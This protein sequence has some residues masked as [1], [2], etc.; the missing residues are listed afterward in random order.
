MVYPHYELAEHFS[1]ASTCARRE[2]EEAAKDLRVAAGR[3]VLA[4]ARSTTPG[5]ASLLDCAAALE[6]LADLIESGGHWQHHNLEAAFS[7]A[8]AAV[9]NAQY[10]RLEKA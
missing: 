5:R 4:G 1:R 10:L 2:P 3:L 6:R 9:A 7:A 8:R